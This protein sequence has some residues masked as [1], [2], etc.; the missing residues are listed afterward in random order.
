M[1]DTSSH[2]HRETRPERECKRA[3]TD[4][5]HSECRNQPR[6]AYGIDQRAAGQLAGQG[7]KAARGQDQADIELRPLMGSQIDCNERTKTGLNVRKEEGEP[8]KTARTR[9]RRRTRCCGRRLLQCR[10][11]R[12]TDVGAA[13][14]PTAV[15]LK[16]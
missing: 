6:R 16:C 15:K 5:R 4:R 2:D 12:K 7:D 13:V 3:Q 1:K 8:V 10:Q 14:E 9:P 11:R